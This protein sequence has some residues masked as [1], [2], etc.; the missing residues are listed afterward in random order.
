MKMDFSGRRH[1]CLWL[2]ALV[3]FFCRGA[4]ASLLQII[5]TND[6]HSHFEHSSHEGKG[7]YAAVKAVIDKIKW[8]AWDKGIETIVVD[9][10]DFSEGTQFYLADRGEQSW[11]AMNVMG[12]DAVVVGNHDYLLG[13][14]GLERVVTNS[15]PDFFLLGANFHPGK[16]YKNLYKT[17]QP[18]ARLERNGD[19]VTVMGLTTDEF[20]YTWRAGKNVITSPK[21]TVNSLV[22]K[23]RKDSAFVIAVTH[24]GVEADRKLVRETKGID[25]IVGGHSHDALFSP[26][27]EKAADGRAVPIVQA[28]EH[29]EYVGDLLVDL[30]PG[31]PAR[32]VRYQLVPVD[33]NG[34]RDR[35]MAAFV[36]QARKRLE[37]TYPGNW[38]SAEL[39]Y[40]EAPLKRPKNGTS[41]WDDILGRGM[42]LVSKA[43]VAFNA[44]DLYGDELP[45]GPITRERLIQY[46]PRVFEFMNFTTGWSVWTAEV[47]GWV[48][49]YFVQEVIRRGFQLSVTG[50]SFK[51][52][53]AKGKESV[54]DFK[55]NGS[56]VTSIRTY[57][58]ALPEGIARV[59]ANDYSYSKMLE[60]ISCTKVS[61]WAAM[62]LQ[63]RKLGGY[64]RETLN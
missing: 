17:M 61:M 20:M 54:T 40:S 11:K 26:I 23:Y 49:K 56:G 32:V 43:D 46:Y 14:D 18:R 50:A 34:T 53:G 1:G 21:D 5:H 3:L 16:Q 8:A 60:P 29:G 15:K 44:T 36:E 24:L 10:G 64:V 52:T 59:L 28:G 12:Y 19:Y 27:V 39:G 37:A 48:L 31:K 33:I 51:V 35:D 13:Q 63:L 22:P 45:P 55:I 38:L 47:E 58:V 41:T 9:A 2:V 6:L 4:S 62:E 30:T 25:L 42:M 57:K 7:H